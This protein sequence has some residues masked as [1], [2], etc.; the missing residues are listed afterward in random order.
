MPSGQ[1]K[2]LVQQQ[3]RR[4]DETPSQKRQRRNANLSD[5]HRSRVAI[6]LRTG[7]MADSKDDRARLD[8]A[9]C[10]LLRKWPSLA[11]RVWTKNHPTFNGMPDVFGDMQKRHPQLPMRDLRRGASGVCMRIAHTQATDS[12]E[13]KFTSIAGYDSIY[14]TAWPSY[15]RT[16][17]TLACAY[18][19]REI[20]RAL[21]VEFGCALDARTNKVNEE[22]G[23][24]LVDEHGNER[25]WRMTGLDLCIEFGSLET[26]DLL[27][28]LES[29]HPLVTASAEYR[30]MSHAMRRALCKQNEKNKI[31]SCADASRAAEGLEFYTEDTICIGDSKC[32]FCAGNK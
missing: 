4:A 31:A 13:V 10:G 6:H 1:V 32:D 2:R 30:G 22:E 12:G 7:I 26:F 27:V 28:T 15:R 11:R 25:E 8:A 9:V 18:N 3:D 14:R 21:V 17:F 23:L 19:R 29:A 16:P 24:V 5:K 20:V